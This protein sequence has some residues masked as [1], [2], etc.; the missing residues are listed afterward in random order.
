MTFK[1]VIILV[2]FN[3]EQ[4]EKS[5]RYQRNSLIA[6]CRPSFYMP[7]ELLKTIETQSQREHSSRSGFVTNLLFFLLLSPIGKQLQK[8]ASLNRRTIAQELEQSLVLFQQQLPLHQINQLAAA[9]QRSQAQMMTYLVLLGLQ[10]Y[11]AKERLNKNAE[12]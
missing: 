2:I 4:P 12:Y 3:S 1:S 5:H 7:E 11:Q 6:N 8:N 10:A 9:T